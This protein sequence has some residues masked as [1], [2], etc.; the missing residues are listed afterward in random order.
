MAFIPT[1]GA[2]RVDIQFVQTGQQI[3]NIIWARREAAWTQTEREGLADA[4]ETW[5]TT[6]ARS[7]F[8]NNIALSQITVVNQDAFN[9]PSTVHVVS[10]TV[11]G[12]VAQNSV[13]TNAALCATLRTDLRGRSFRGRMYLAGWSQTEMNNA[14]TATTTLIA[15]LIADLVAL[16]GVIDALGAIWVIV[17]K[18][19]NKVPRAAG[20]CT[21]ITAVSMDQYIDSQRRRLGLRGV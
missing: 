2:V 8:T 15:N 7:H 1:A 14:I 5:W 6:T 16:K 11:A 20:L 17:S 12:T 3:H 13:P 18:W 21:P 19:S 4:I 10:P 9:S